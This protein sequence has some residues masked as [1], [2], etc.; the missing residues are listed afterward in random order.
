L[1]GAVFIGMS[2]YNP[3]EKRGENKKTIGTILGTGF[4]VLLVLIIFSAIRIVPAG[5]VGIVDFFGKVSP[6]VLNSGLNLVNPFAKVI[7]ISVRTQEDK[8][9]MSVP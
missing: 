3:V 2:Y 9:T 6:N 5:Y 1:L 8:E 7:A 4:V